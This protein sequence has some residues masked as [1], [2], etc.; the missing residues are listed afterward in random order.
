[1]ILS[2]KT[3]SSIYSSITALSMSLKEQNL[4]AGERTSE[5][6]F[7]LESKLFA[8]ENLLFCQ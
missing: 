7:N 8:E 4:I 6:R 1:L 5:V 2:F 3:I